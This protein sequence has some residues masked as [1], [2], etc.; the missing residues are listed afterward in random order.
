V[1]KTKFDSIVKLK[2]SELDNINQELS[3]ISTQLDKE[4]QKLEILENELA[5]FDYPKS[6]NFALVSQFKLLQ[7]AKRDEIKKQKE[8]ILSLQ[9]SKQELLKQL[10]QINIEYEKIKYIQTQEIK[11][12]IDQN[13]K[14][15]AKELD[16]IALM[17]FK[18]EK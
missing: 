4:H 18:G 13:R 17:L 14:K 16:E 12:I 10:Q 11:K 2:K 8:Y 3:K 6:G 5:S 9:N 7:N 15:E 1:V